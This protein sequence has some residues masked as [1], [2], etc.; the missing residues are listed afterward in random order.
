LIF[1]LLIPTQ[2]QDEDISVAF[3]HLA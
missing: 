3:N 2:D 1:Q